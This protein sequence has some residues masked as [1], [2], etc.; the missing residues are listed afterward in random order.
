MKMRRTFKV[1]SIFP[2]L[3]L[4]IEGGVHKSLSSAKK[5]LIKLAKLYPHMT[6][7][8][9]RTETGIVVSI[10]SKQDAVEAWKAGKTYGD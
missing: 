2:N 3:G 8:I 9:E 1:E 5:E 7:N 4:Y 10:D 6:H